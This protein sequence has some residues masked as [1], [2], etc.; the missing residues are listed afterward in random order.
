GFYPRTHK[1]SIMY[2]PPANKTRCLIYTPVK[3]KNGML[4]LFVENRAI[5]EFYPIKEKTIRHYLGG[6]GYRTVSAKVAHEFATGLH[7]L[8]SES[9]VTGI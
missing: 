8:F 9:G 7:R 1:W 6:S 2:A 3:P 4:N 5:A